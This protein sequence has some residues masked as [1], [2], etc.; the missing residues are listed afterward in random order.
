MPVCVSFHAFNEITENIWTD[1]DAIFV[2]KSDMILF[3]E[4]Y[5]KFWDV[6]DDYVDTGKLFFY[7]FFMLGY[8]DSRSSK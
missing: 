3:V 5:V 4:Q 6:Q 7:F 1:F 8:T 2:D